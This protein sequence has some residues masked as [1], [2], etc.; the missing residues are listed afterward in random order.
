MRGQ[1]VLA[2]GVCVPLEHCAA[3]HHCA[4]RTINIS[5]K[6]WVRLVGQG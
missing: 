2:E 4:L 5:V 1:V 6:Q 3:T